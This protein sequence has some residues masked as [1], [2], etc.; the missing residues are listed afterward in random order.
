MNINIWYGYIVLLGTD[1]KCAILYSF[2][3]QFFL[4]EKRGTS[5]GQFDKNY[6]LGVYDP[7]Q[8]IIYEYYILEK[9][10]AI[11]FYGD[12]SIQSGSK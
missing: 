11:M 3:T 7:M 4:F 12:I 9:L 10:L 1:N 5:H 2:S 6:P 8:Y